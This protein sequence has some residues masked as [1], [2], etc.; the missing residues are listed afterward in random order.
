MEAVDM[1]PIIRVPDDVAQ[2]LEEETD[3]VEDVIDVPYAIDELDVQL[4]ATLGV[5][6]L[7]TETPKDGFGRLV[8]LIAMSDYAKSAP[9]PFE[10][11][12][13]DK[14][15]IPHAFPGTAVNEQSIRDHLKLAYF[16]ER[17]DR[18]PLIP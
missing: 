16:G 12:V 18:R 10:L 17:G 7:L 2:R 14:D 6:L 3:L 11:I 9:E 13:S 8:S 15:S 5:F 1:G 4:G